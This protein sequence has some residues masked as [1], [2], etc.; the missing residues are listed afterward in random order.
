M[1]TKNSTSFWVAMILLVALSVF[2]IISFSGDGS[3]DEEKEKMTAMVSG[4][5]SVWQWVNVVPSRDTSERLYKGVTAAQEGSEQLIK[6]TENVKD[7][8]LILD[9]KY[10]KEGGIFLREDSQGRYIE[11]TGHD[12]RSHIFRLPGFIGR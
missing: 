3:P 6:N 12:G 5:T 11:I 8:S 2:S 1:T 4:V 7:F 10:Q 9:N